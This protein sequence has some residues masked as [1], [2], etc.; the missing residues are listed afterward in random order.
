M[1]K[2]AIIILHY[3]N[4]KYIIVFNNL[5]VNFQKKKV[6]FRLICHPI[7][8]IA[9]MANALLV[10]NVVIFGLV[11]VTIRAIAREPL[12]HVLQEEVP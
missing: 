7:V 5:S 6:I 9:T 10:Q 3:I 8:S 2:S 11:V 4:Y 1:H 12:R